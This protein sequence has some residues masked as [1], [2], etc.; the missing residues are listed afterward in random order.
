LAIDHVVRVSLE[1]GVR[2]LLHE[3]RIW[4]APELLDT[5]LSDKR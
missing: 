3:V 5:F 2:V 4:N 1:G